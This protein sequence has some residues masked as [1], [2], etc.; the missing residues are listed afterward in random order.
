MPD[1]HPTPF[2]LDA[3]ANSL[4][5]M[6]RD[7]PILIRMPDGSLRPVIGVRPA[8]LSGDQQELPE[9]SYT[10]AALYAITLEVG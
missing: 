2:T 4:R 6:P 9:G 5:G 8:H 7:A 10:G 1:P 3:L